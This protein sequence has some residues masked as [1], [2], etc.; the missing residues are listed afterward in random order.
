MLLRCFLSALVLQ[1]C[2][3]SSLLFAGEK[4]KPKSEDPDLQV[5][6]FKMHYFA[7]P[8][9]VNYPSCLAVSPGGAVFIGEDPYNVRANKSKTGTI[10]KFVD[11]KGEGKADKAT[12]F[13]ENTNGPRGMCYVDGTLYVVAAPTLIAYKDDGSGKAA[14]EDVLISGYGF[15]PE[16]LAPDHSEAGVRMAIDGWLYLAVGDQGFLKAVSKDKI[17]LQLHGGGLC[18]IR[19][20]GTEFEIF[21]RGTRNTYDI[22]IDP[23][24]NGYTRDNTNDG[25]KWNTRLAHMIYGAEY[26]YPSLFVNYS[27]ENLPCLADVGNGGAT[28]ALF[29]QEP[30][31]PEGFSNTLLTCDWANGRI[32][33]H[34]LEAD[35]ATFKIKQDNFYKG[36]R[37]TDLDVDGRGRIFVSDWRGA[38][39]GKE[40]DPNKP[41]GF[42]SVIENEKGINPAEFPDLNKAADNILVGYIASESQVLRLNAQQALLRRPFKQENATELEK[43]FSGNAPL[44]ARVAA[45]F[46]YKQM[47]GVKAHPAI[48]K[49]LAN[50]EMKEFAIRALADRKS[51]FE[52]LDPKLFIDALAD[53]NPRV[54]VQAIIALMRLNKPETASALVPLLTD[55]DVEVSH[56]AMRGLRALNAVDI[57]LDAASKGPSDTAI[58]ALKTLREMHEEKVVKGLAKLQTETKDEKFRLLITE[59]IA[60]LFNVEMPWDSYVE[61]PGGRWW[62]IPPDTTGP[63]YKNDKWAQSAEIAKILSAEF[64]KGDDTLKAAIFKMIARYKIPPGDLPGALAQISDPKAKLTPELAHV[65]VQ[66]DTFKLD[67]S[68]QLE[69]IALE[70]SFDAK[71]RGDAIEAFSRVSVDSKKKE[72]VTERSAAISRSL[73]DLALAKDTPKEVNTGIANLLKNIDAKYVNL[74]DAGKW[75]ASSSGEVREGAFTLLLKKSTDPAAKA[76]FEIAWKDL[77]ATESLLKAIEKNKALEFAEKVQ[78]FV[79]DKNGG[80]SGA[81]I[82]AAGTLGDAIAFEAL[83]DCA[84]KNHH[85]T[86]ALTALDKLKTDKVEPGRFAT[87]AERAVKLAETDATAKDELP[88]LSR[89]LANRFAEDKK[90]PAEISKALKERLVKVGGASEPLI[91]DFEPSD[92]KFSATGEPRYKEMLAKML[93]EHGDK[94]KGQELFTSLGCIKCHTLTQKDPP[95]GPFLG[96][97]GSKNKRPDLIESII[98]PS[99]KLVMGYEPVMLDVDGVKLTGFKTNDSG[100]KFELHLADGEFKVIQ[101]KDVEKEKKLKLSIM[102]SGLV[103]KLTYKQ[104]ASL[105]EYLESLQK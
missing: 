10:K 45:L 91:G 46:T 71:T 92:D 96:D 11:T 59:T 73:N 26:G 68:A 13:A 1:A 43:N 9:E 6:G 64:D 98:L 38:V 69:R 100:D 63:H 81:A 70:K 27:D 62:G 54:R 23:L 102:P 93:T 35:G 21:C 99:E 74:A 90:L 89:A 86:V 22:A 20:D 25:R 50:P 28:G 95:K 30:Y 88:V 87:L 104:F 105:L 49:L 7:L 84:E 41:V 58:A 75:A 4:A 3:A 52:G 48:Q 14:S 55:K 80:V 18:R 17:E 44:Y 24:L 76:A 82:K 34:S 77:P 78:G 61:S 47:L 33:T 94:A 79:H 39:Y 72:Q 97:I 31:M 36:T 56:L 16:Q 29:V 19:P 83:F 2:L 8:P 5:K 51:Q 42:I 53:A 101:K 67:Q 15:T 57:C 60:R 85:A 40:K 66:L 37:P 12:V 65:I 103:S 32:H